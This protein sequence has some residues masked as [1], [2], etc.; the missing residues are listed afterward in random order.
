MSNVLTHRY[1]SPKLDGPDATQVQPSAWNDGHR[2]TGGAT[3]DVLT[4]DAADATF[5][6]KWVTPPVDPGWVAYTAQWWV[7]GVQITSLGTHQILRAFVYQRGNI[8]WFQ[9]L[10]QTGSDPIPAGGWS[11]TLP[12]NNV[13]LRP[14]QGI[15]SAA[16]SVRPLVLQAEASNRAAVLYLKADQTLAAFTGTVPIAIGAGAYVEINGNFLG[17]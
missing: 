13:T 2:F 12:L 14:G 11:F 16:G 4:R 10:F 7:G 1:V 5:G 6:A 3:G 8:V 17:Y 9:L 15:L